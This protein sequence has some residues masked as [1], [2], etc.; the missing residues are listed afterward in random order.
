[1]NKYIALAALVVCSLATKAQEPTDKFWHLQPHNKKGN[2]GIGLEE[3]KEMM[4]GKT[5]QTVVVAIADAGVDIYHPDL[6][7]MLWINT[8]EI[9]DN[10]VDDDNNGYID[11]TYG[12]NFLGETTFDNMELTREYAR[13]NTKYELKPEDN[14][15]DIEEYNT[16]LT[17]KESYLE[18]Q[19]EAK[20]TFMILKQ[21]MNGMNAIEK[22]YGKDMTLEE[23]TNHKP[24]NK[25]EQIG[26]LVLLAT[27][28]K[29]KEPFNFQS[30]K[31]E[32]QEGYDQYD[33]MYNYG[34]N[35]VF[36]PRPEKVGDDYE[37]ATEQ[38]YG[39]NKVYYGERFSSHGTHVAGIVAADASNDFGAKGICQS[40]KIMSIRNV[41]E[42]DERDK[43][44]ANGI[45]YA[46]DNDA[47][48]VNMSFGKGYSYRP[49]V[50][51][52]AIRYAES[53]GVLLI[54]AAGN[55]GQN[56]DNTN[57]F[58]NDSKNEFNNWL[59][60]GACSWEKKPSAL[61]VFSN[62]G[63]EE[64]DLFSPGV[65]IY[66]T[67]PENNYE[68]FDGTSMASPVAA[69]VAA[70]VWSYYPSLTA[71]QLK[72]ILIDSAIPIKGRNRIPGSR[73][74]KKVTELSVTG[75][76]INLPAALRMAQYIVNP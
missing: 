72:R 56:N 17:L 59:E 26:K 34:F 46:V 69:G 1:M 18:K 5:P 12:W 42:G 51:K 14:I 3:A 19:L 43:D 23:V 2:S 15:V 31:D 71:A 62:Y 35:A 41:P 8:D 6:K 53:K 49:E 54:H 22:N 40:C 39:N 16:Y 45:R 76:E 21:M 9:P 63:K 10:N 44:V 4:K 32:I 58:P 27:A 11:D 25:Y 61:A 66:S 68:A 24:Q 52:E 48:I 67:T 38:G 60:V 47:K 57:N 37:N 29:S 73:K 33:F 64:V 36:N 65:A 70:F 28:K 7:N 30:I 55:S 74:R 75:A 13:L 50:V 20:Q